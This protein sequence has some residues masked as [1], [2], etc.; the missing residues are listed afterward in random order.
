MIAKLILA[1]LLHIQL[2]PQ[3]KQGVNMMKFAMNHPH[4]FHNWT[5]GFING[6]FYFIIPMAIEIATAL[7]LAP[8]SEPVVYD[9]TGYIYLAS[10]SIIPMVFAYPL[11]QDPLY[12]L[13]ISREKPVALTIDRT[14]SKSNSW[15]GEKYLDSKFGNNFSGLNIPD[16][17][18]T[19]WHQIYTQEETRTEKKP[20]FYTAQA[21][22]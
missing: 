5:S 10:I 21:N 4:R 7:Y 22:H 8:M 12:K 15:Y 9:L 19:E 13:L 3:A 18:Y 1:V 14:S 17:V 6:F 16:E 11:K 20:G 2:L